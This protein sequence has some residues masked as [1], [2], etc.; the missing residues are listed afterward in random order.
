MN[1]RSIRILA[2]AALTLTTATE[3]CAQNPYVRAGVS[4]SI[5]SDP[6]ARAIGDILTVTIQEQTTVQNEERVERRNDTSL[7]ARL[8]TFSLSDKTFKGST[9]PRIDIRKE[10]DF[11]GEA[12]QNSG[13]NV[14]ASIAVVV[15]DVQP[16][17]NLVIAGARQVTVNDETRTL[18]I[19]G[20]VRQL[21]VTPDNTVGSAQVAE[22]RIAILGDGGN[23]RQVT[24]GPVG[25]MFD[26]LMWVV[27]PF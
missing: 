11:Q 26:T 2:T 22:A 8:E 12:R 9:L 13:S 17:G 23:T 15:I 21:D 19:S 6:R 25:Q 3:L 16:N 4:I 7:A 20:I 18:K 10:S 24:R 14:Q 5:A 1:T 27:W